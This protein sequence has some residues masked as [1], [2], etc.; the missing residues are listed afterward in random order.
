[1]TI[2]PRGQAG[3]MTIYLPEEDTAYY[4]K[5]YME[6][7]LI[8]LL[9]GRVAEALMLG[10]ISTGASNDLM[11][12]T[13]MARKMVGTYGMSEKIGAVAFDAGSDEVFIGKSMGHPRPYSEKTAAEMDE[14]IRA[15]IDGCYARAETILTENRPALEAV[16]QHLLQHETLSGEEFESICRQS[17]TE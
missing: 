17:E 3:G 2:V 12:A 6:E 16:A 1:V 7:Q 15:I 10:D 4:S 14:E 8:T 5:K 11:R 9:G 13:T